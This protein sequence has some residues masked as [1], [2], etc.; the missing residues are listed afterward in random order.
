MAITLPQPSKCFHKNNE[1]S[2]D[3]GKLYISFIY[4]I[5]ASYVNIYIYISSISPTWT[6]H[7][8]LEVATYIYIYFS[9]NRNS[10]THQGGLLSQGH[11]FGWNLQKHPKQ[12]HPQNLTAKAPE[13]W[14]LED[15]F[16]SFWVSA[17]FQGRKCC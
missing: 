11:K 12:I 5:Y 16:V 9:V 17:Y 15:F 4:I 6:I 1:K 8:K 7:E 10:Q 2:K 13:N 14:W 3:L